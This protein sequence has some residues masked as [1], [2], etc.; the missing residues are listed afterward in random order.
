MKKWM[1][2][3]LAMGLLL[4]LTAC[5][6]V[7]PEEDAATVVAE[8]NGEAITKG[9]ATPFMRRIPSRQFPIIRRWAAPW[10]P[11]TRALSPI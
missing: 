9:E 3:L 8:V 2:L 10:T 11:R 4:A 5:G 7:S 1:A 6:E